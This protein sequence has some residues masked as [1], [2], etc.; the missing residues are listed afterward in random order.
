MEELKT[1]LLTQYVHCHK[2]P[3]IL[4]P[5]ISHDDWAEFVVLKT[6]PEFVPKSAK[7]RNRA[8]LRK[9]AQIGRASCRERV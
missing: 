4:H 2:T 8:Y 3:V 7:A 1:K 5:S 9:N 6:K